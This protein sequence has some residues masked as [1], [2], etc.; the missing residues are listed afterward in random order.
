[1]QTTLQY[2]Y[3]HYQIPCI[4][5]C[6]EHEGMIHAIFHLLRRNSDNNDV[7]MCFHGL[8]NVGEARMLGDIEV[9]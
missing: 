5:A 2:Q 6:G 9:N 7:F 8:K 1:M 3:R 4:S